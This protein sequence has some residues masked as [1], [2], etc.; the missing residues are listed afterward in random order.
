MPKAPEIQ[1]LNIKGQTTLEPETWNMG[2]QRLGN[3]AS[4]PTYLV[5]VADKGMPKTTPIR[6][7]K[8]SDT[9]KKVTITIWPKFCWL[10]NRPNQ[11]QLLNQDH[12]DVPNQNYQDQL[13]NRYRH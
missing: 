3:G 13:V 1:A 5:N 4:Q 10:S 7:T 12:P 8:Y 11:G 2:I 9:S 6:Y